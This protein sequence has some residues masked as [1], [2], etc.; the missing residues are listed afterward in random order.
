MSASYFYYLESLKVGA[1]RPIGLG[2]WYRQ[3][4][5]VLYEKLWVRSPPLL[6]DAALF[7]AGLTVAEFYVWTALNIMP[8]HEVNRERWRNRRT[9]TCLKI[10]I[11]III[12]MIEGLDPNLGPALQL[13]CYRS[14]LFFANASDQPFAGILREFSG[15]Y[16]HS[17]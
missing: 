3:L 13:D 12:I 4:Q 15:H 10:P 8:V 17:I 11:I 6:R 14:D 5:A 9:E 2:L 16:S 7:T 1:G